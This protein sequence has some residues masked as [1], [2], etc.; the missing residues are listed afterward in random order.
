MSLFMLV[1]L[2]KYLDWLRLE[3]D[4][5]RTW[6]FLQN[7][8]KPMDIIYLDLDDF[9]IPKVILKVYVKNLVATSQFSTTKLRKEQSPPYRW[10][11]YLGIW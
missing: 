4:N 6:S 7:I 10:Y 3:V 9:H 5:L 11:I 1:T 8:L 2:Q